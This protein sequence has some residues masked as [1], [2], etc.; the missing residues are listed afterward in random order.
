VTTHELRFPYMVFARASGGGASHSLILSGMPAADPE[1]LGPPE[2]PDLAFA[3]EALAE[4]QAALGAHLGVSP[5]R[6]IVTV[7]ASSAMLL[8]ALTYFRGARVASEVPSYEPLRALPGLVGGELRPLIRRHEE[9]WAVDPAAVRSALAGGS[10]PG[11]VLLTTP[12]NPSG[13]ALEPDVLA[14][15]AAEAERAGG[16]L[17]AGEVYLEFVPRARRR[18]VLELAPNVLSIGSLT[19]A[20]GLGALRL[21]W[22]ALGEAVAGDRRRLEDAAFLDYVDPP[23]PILRLGIRA[24]RRLDRLREPYE[25]LRRESRPVLA[26]WLEETAGIEGRAPEHGLICFPRIEGVSDT[27][28][29][30]RALVARHDVDAVPGEFFGC[31]GHLR[32]GYGLEPAA[33]ADALGRLAEGVAD[34]RG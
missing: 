22:I 4:L 31:A 29:L 15:V 1:L 21:G 30:Q 14:A 10:G 20:Y 8:T 32:I 6:V 23:T 2:P 12:H 19:K 33:L 18:S 27:R 9:D 26:R 25:L 16:L 5:E 11:H 24:A 3:G 7:G 13:T 28:A 34:F 17:I